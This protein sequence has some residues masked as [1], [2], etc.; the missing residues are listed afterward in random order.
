MSEITNWKLQYR[1][2]P[3]LAAQTPCSLYSVLLEH[4][5]IP[6]PYQDRNEAQ[7]RDL[8]KDDCEFTA[9]F[10]LEETKDM[11]IVFQSLDTICDVYVNDVLLGKTDNMHVEY[12]FDLEGA[13]H[14]GENMVRVYCHSP[15]R[16]ITERQ[17]K[18]SLIAQP[19]CIEGMAHIRKPN[20]AFGWDWGPQ[21]PDMGIQGKVYLQ[22]KHVK[23]KR[24]I[25]V[26]QF[27]KDN[28]VRL[29]IVFE[30]MPDNAKAQARLTDGNTCIEQTIV[31]KLAVLTVEQ[32]KLWW[33]RGYGEQHLYTLTVLVED[34]RCGR[35]EITQQIG[36]R[37]MKISRD[38]D[39]VGEEF[40]FMVNGVKIFAM[41]ADLIPVDNILPLVT[42]ERE[43]RVIDDAVQARFNCVR[44]WGGGYYYSEYFYEECDKCGILIW[45]DFMFACQSV[46]LSTAYEKSVRE[47]AKQ[48]I[49]RYRNHASLAL[50]CGNNEIEGAFLWFPISSEGAKME[51]LQLFEQLLPD[52]CEQYAPDV[53]YWPSSP[54]AGGGFHDTNTYERGDAHYWETWF[55]GRDMEVFR[56]QQ[57]RFCS[58]FGFEALPAPETLK[59]YIT[60]AKELNFYSKTIASHHKC[61]NGAAMIM[62][63]LADYYPYPS[64]IEEICY[65]SQLRQADVIAYQVEHARRMRGVFMGMIYWQLNDS[66]PTISWSSVDYCGRYKALYYISSQIFAPVLLSLHLYNSDVTVNV[67]NETREAFSGTIGVTLY[68]E[69]FQVLDVYE[70]V[71]EVAALSSKDIS[72]LHMTDK[73]KGF[74]DSRYLY[75]VLK[76][77]AGDIVGEKLLTFERPKNMK[78]SDPNIRVHTEQ[79]D[80]KT[81]ITLMARTLAMYVFVSVGDVN[82]SE[83]YFHLANGKSVTITAEGAYDENDVHV[84]SLYDVIIKN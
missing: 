11:V 55:H 5:L 2:N 61:K 56:T 38:K 41:G 48:I 33:P 51:Y 83:N 18:W 62:S 43:K 20:Y 35:Y 42:R 32:P 79:R 23:D 13:A 68:G 39:M 53:F 10:T 40:C 63:K 72:V 16:Y 64:N 29:E 71:A 77:E 28:H 36:L 82:L 78:L 26:R 21:L 80:G 57:I 9:S 65:L 37:D 58:E 25:L 12:R 1:D 75:A 47:E 22:N 31:N 49:K 52:L 46:H 59:K 74:E 8:C 15:I 6:H 30:N 67:S 34:A 27:H 54:S 70:S 76:N 81:W 19:D 73:I 66:W 7:I 3:P 60:D 44:I 4:K 50:F 69:N 24:D 17:N 14:P 84:M 45:Q